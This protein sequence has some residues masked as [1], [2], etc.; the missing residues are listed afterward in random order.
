MNMDMI[1]NRAFLLITVVL[2]IASCSKT[3]NSKQQANKQGSGKIPVE[4][5]IINGQMIDNMIFSTG[6]LLANE[7]ADLKPEIS[8]RITG[9]HFK[10]GERVGKGQLL[11]KINDSELK[12]QLAKTEILE[13]QASDDESRKRRLLEINA[14]SQEEFDNSLNALNAIKADKSFVQAQLEKTSIIA[15]FDGVIGL[16]QV[17][18]G[19]YVNTGQILA[20]IKSINP[21]KLEFSV[22]EKYSGLIRPGFPVT[23]L[24]SSSDKQYEGK[25]YAIEPGI[26]A[27]TRAFKVR[28]LCENIDQKLYPGAFAKVSVNLGRIENAMMIPSGALIPQING[29][30]AFVYKSGKVMNT[31]VEIGLRTSNQVQVTKGL[32]IGD[33]LICSGLLQIREGSEVNVIKVQNQNN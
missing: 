27:E 8:G 1:F 23:F 11:F 6:T 16:R 33:T 28:A 4:V 13:K 29:Q 30:K 26:D 2:L 25:V 5:M 10:E 12:A 22:P 7:E 21:L 20:N 24:L 18:P 15:P 32:S 19:S 14:I 3:D 9:I 17:S 31:D